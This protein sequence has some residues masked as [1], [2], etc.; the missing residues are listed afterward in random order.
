MLRLTLSVALLAAFAS[1]AVAADAPRTIDWEA[2][3]PE[4]SAPLPPPPAGHPFEDPSTAM[5]DDGAAFEDPWAGFSMGV[6]EELDGEEIR[7]PGYIVP[8]D[9]AESGT[10]AEFLLVPYL[11]ACIHVPPPPPNQIVFVQMD[12]P[13]EIEDIW[14]PFWVEGTLRTRNAMTELADAAYTLSGRKVEAYR[15]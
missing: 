15:W 10:F 1:L 8:L 12:E 9:L 3:I 6:V 11:G 2:L 5:L 4:G 13:V 14:V 7:M